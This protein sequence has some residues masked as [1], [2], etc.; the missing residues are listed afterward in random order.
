M[1]VYSR[2]FYDQKQKYDPKNLKA[3]DYQPVKLETK[4]LSDEN[5]SDLKQLTQLK[6]PKLN[7]TSKP[8]WINLSRE[9]FNSLIKNVVDNLG[10]EDHKTTVNNLRHDLENAEKFSLEVITKKL[11]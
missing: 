2:F 1:A 3:L 10:H 11:V 7:K 8:L 6:K 9:N 4:S 5:R